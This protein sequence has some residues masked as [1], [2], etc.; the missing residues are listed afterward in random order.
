[1]ML[2][3]E[4]R[5]QACGHTFE[6]RQS[7]SD[8]PLQECPECRG[9]VQRLATGGTGFIL[10]GPDSGRLEPQGKSC[11]YEQSGITCCGRSERCGRPSCDSE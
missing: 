6:W 7:I 4:Y 5:C 3:Y 9:P 10:K 8:P 1:M 2:T 11:S